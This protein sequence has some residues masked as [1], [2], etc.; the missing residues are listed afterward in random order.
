MQGHRLA[1]DIHRHTGRADEFGTEQRHR[2]RPAALAVDDIAARLQPGLGELVGQIGDG[3]GFAGGGRGAALE[4]VRAER[5]D[6]LRQA[7]GVELGRLGEGGAA[8]EDQGEGG[9]GDELVTQ[10][11]GLLTGMKAADVWNRLPLPS[12]KL[13][14]RHP[15]PLTPPPG[16]RR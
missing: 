10:G 9:Q 4:R 3:L 6:M 16:R 15:V 8:G 7:G 13:P 12:R 1:G 5:L 14:S 11:R 2:L